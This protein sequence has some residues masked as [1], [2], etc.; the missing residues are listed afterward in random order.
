MDTRGGRK[1]EQVYLLVSLG[2]SCSQSA[3]CEERS[4][5]ELATKI[6]PVAGF[7]PNDHVTG[8]ALVAVSP[9]VQECSINIRATIW[10]TSALWDCRTGRTER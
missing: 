5:Q 2:E 9:S 1:W 6:P 7:L 3:V 10:R 8:L 4:W